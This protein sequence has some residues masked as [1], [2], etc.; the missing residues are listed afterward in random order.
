MDEAYFLATRANILAIEAEI[1]GMVSLNQYRIS[2][3]E[4]IAYDECSFI[5]KADELRD[6]ADFLMRY[7]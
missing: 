6:I 2:R 1:Q 3:G 4:T 7:R 5:K